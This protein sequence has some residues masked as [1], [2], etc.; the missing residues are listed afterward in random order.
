MD[1]SLRIPGGRPNATVIGNHIVEM[2]ASG[3]PVF[4][5]RSWDHFEIEDAVHEDLTGGKIDYVHMNSLEFDGDGNLLAS[6]RHLS[7]ITKIDRRTGDILWRLGGVN[8]DF[9]WTNDEHRISYQHTIQTL[10]GG[11]Y[12]IFDNGNQHEVPFSRALEVELDT[13]LWTATRVW[14]FRDVPDRYTWAEGSCQRLENGNTLVNW[15]RGNLPKATEVRPDGRKVFEMN[16]E[17]E[18]RSYRSFRQAWRGKAAVP[19]LMAEPYSDRITL[20]FNKFGDPG[21]VSYNVYGGPHPEPEE[22]VAVSEAPFVHL[23]DLPNHTMYRFRVTAVDA[24]GEE[25]GF[26]NE[27]E[28][29]VRFTSPG[30][31]IL[32]NG[33]FSEGFEHWE[34]ETENAEAAFRIDGGEF[35]FLIADGGAASEQVRASYPH[36]RLSRGES[37]LFEFDAYAE[38][39]RPF[40]AE[41]KRAASPGVNYSRMGS[42]WLTRTRRRFSKRFVMGDRDETDARVF[43]N[44][45]GSNHDVFVDDVTLMQVVTD[46]PEPGSPLPDGY[47]LGNN[48]PNPFNGYTVIEYRIPERSRVRLTVFDV[49]GNLVE[50]LADA[51]LEEGTHRIG[52]DASRVGS[53]MY[54]VAMH[55]RAA[56]GGRSFRTAKKLMVLK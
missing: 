5:W 12:L 45:G 48:Y 28:V 51:L 7:E 40:E 21:T 19:F 3:D 26:S 38:E 16:F 54:L 53:G 11:R 36:I 2:D 23:T 35:R 44:A 30:T 6:S 47:V 15:S 25:S 8:D 34:F 52:F 14:E 42:V 10:P 18:S 43:L 31:N 55:A 49:H 41:V 50:E 39:E 4:V 22:I 9:R 33:D 56:D 37:Y 32:R 20:I 27:V 17:N 24:S 29:F 13:V 46:V 1:M